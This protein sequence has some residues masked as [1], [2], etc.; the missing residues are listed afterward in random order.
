MSVTGAELSRIIVAR[1]R[2]LGFAAAG[3]CAAAASAYREELAAWLRDGKHGTMSY[4]ADDLADRLDPQ[5]VLP[6]VRAVIMVGDLYARRGD[7]D[8]GRQRFG[9]I[10]R[11]A[12]GR[13]YHDVVRRRLHGLAD[14]LRREHAG[15]EFRTFVDSAPVL[16][17]EYAA[18]S[19][20][21]WIAKNTMLIHPR[22]GSYLVLGGIYTT[23]DLDPPADQVIEADH[24]GTCTRCIDAC[25]TRAITPYSVDGSR[26]ISY[27]TIEHEPPIETHRQREIGDWLYGCDICQEVCP[28][29]SARDGADVGEVP[30][31]YAPRRSGLDL[32]AVLH[33]TPDDRERAFETSAMKRATL[34]MM[35]RNAIIVAANLIEREGAIGELSGPIKALLERVRL[36]AQDE[37]EPALVTQ[38]ARQVLE[39]LAG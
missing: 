3:V 13:D 2:E 24:C 5:R 31:E 14:I 22:V 26:C 25:P 21:G 8:G 35:K 19:G 34:A 23:L 4:L 33:W 18:R 36:I 17:R 16:E 39:R 27:L 9:K 11:Y 12:R 38:T 20:L 7:V 15:A 29:N 6:G 28:H 30:V 10:A 37:S 1:C 32:M